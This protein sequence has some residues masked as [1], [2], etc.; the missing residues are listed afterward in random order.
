MQ[1]RVKR[2]QKLQSVVTIGIGGQL[3][4]VRSEWVKFGAKR[5]FPTEINIFDFSISVSAGA[6]LGVASRPTPYVCLINV[7]CKQ[8][9]TS[10]VSSTREAGKV[11]AVCYLHLAYNSWILGSGWRW[12]CWPTI[13]TDIPLIA[14][15][16]N[17]LASCSSVLHKYLLS[18]TIHNAQTKHIRLLKVYLRTSHLHTHTH[19]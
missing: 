1:W 8:R 18:N 9:S 12:W 14:R 10:K 15:A 2:K 13:Y 16:S 3:A 4:I 5:R 6:L 11:A 17:I 19:T 7:D